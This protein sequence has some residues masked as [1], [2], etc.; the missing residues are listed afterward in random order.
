MEFDGLTSFAWVFRNTNP[1]FEGRALPGTAGALDQSSE[2]AE[3]GRKRGAA[4]FETLDQRLADTPFVAGERFT[5]ADITAYMAIMMARWVKI[6]V[7]D[8]CHNIKRWY[9]EVSQRPSAKA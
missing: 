1:I 8:A 5:I 4:F 7:P 2:M 6:P 9:T 3:I